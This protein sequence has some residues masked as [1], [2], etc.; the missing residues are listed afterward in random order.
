MLGG[1]DLR[2]SNANSQIYVSA[3]I[4]RNFT[5]WAPYSDSCVTQTTELASSSSVSS[6]FCFRRNR[7][8]SSAMLAEM[9]E[10]CR[11]SQVA[12]KLVVQ[13]A[14]SLH[15]QCE[16][17]R[18]VAPHPTPRLARARSHHP[19]MFEALCMPMAFSGLRVPSQSLQSGWKVLQLV[20]QWVRWMGIGCVHLPN[21]N[22][23]LRS[24]LQC[25]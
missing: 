3:T 23:H 1:T 15:N 12:S 9:Q 18:S 11:S 20:L 8:S 24:S 17:I 5:P 7:S 2:K 13:L 4:A 6:S 16:S 22:S 10:C 21:H 25:K 19:S 14:V